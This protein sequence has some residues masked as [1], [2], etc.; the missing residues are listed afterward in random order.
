MMGTD[1]QGFSPLVTR[2]C[3]SADQS[4]KLMMHSW[5]GYSVTTRRITGRWT[6]PQSPSPLGKSRYLN[7]S[8]VDSVTIVMIAGTF[9]FNSFS[10]SYGNELRMRCHQQPQKLEFSYAAGT[11]HQVP[12]P[13]GYSI[14]QGTLCCPVFISCQKDVIS[15][16][17]IKSLSSKT[18]ST[19]VLKKE[20]TFL[21]TNKLKVLF[22]I[23]NSFYLSSLQCLDVGYETCHIWCKRIEKV[24]CCHF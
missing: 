5:N 20:S 24:E 10:P 23:Y 1:P 9:L 17:E 13:N 18:A 2:R 12:N 16:K 22:L 19:N 8:G 14:S 4:L 11:W 3:F 6:P 15:V 7:V 21:V